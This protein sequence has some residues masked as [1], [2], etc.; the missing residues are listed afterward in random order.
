VVSRRRIIGEL[1]SDGRVRRVELA[2]SGFNVAECGV[3]VAVLVYAYERG[4]ATSAAL[5]AVAQLVPAGL[6]A[7]VMAGFVDRSGA[8]RA[9]RRGYCAQAVALGATSL[10]LLGGAPD[11]LVY[12]AAVLA[13][14]AVTTTRPAQAALVP[15]IAESSEQLTAINVL[16]GWVESVSVLAG[17]ALA[18]LLIGLGGPGAA[19]GCFALCVVGSALLAAGVDAEPAAQASALDPAGSDATSWCSG[20]RAVREDRSLAGLVGL[21]GAEYF[22]IGALDLLVVVLAIRDLGLG[23]SGPGYLDAAF[24]AG[25]VIGSVAAGVL[26]GRRQLVGPLLFAASGWAVLLAALGAWPTVM[27]AFLLLAAAGSARSMLDVCGRTILLR[28]APEGVR[29]RLFGLLEGFAMFGLAL[30]SLLVPLLVRLGGSGAALIGTAALL[31]AVA[32]A[33]GPQLRPFGNTGP[34]R[35]ARLAVRTEAPAHPAEFVPAATTT[36]PG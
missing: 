20:L 8:A 2:F 18:A 13:A 11:V 24:G 27:G 35:S 23:P 10:L 29:G 32:L 12:A 26:I 31:S 9:L 16:S 19:V 14:S 22:V 34:A 5:V 7:P 17:P 1:L 4:G 21:L 30:G 6:A 15:A 36:A 3:W 25:G 28:A 33:A